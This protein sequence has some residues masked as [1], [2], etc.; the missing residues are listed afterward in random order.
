[1]QQDELARSIKDRFLAA[2]QTAST[3]LEEMKRLKLAHDALSGNEV[4]EI[5]EDKP[6]ESP[7]PAEAPPKRTRKMKPTLS[8]DDVREVLREILRS[9]PLSEKIVREKVGAFAKEQG[10]AQ[11]SSGHLPRA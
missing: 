11:L 7:S 6:S 10:A 1:M 2:L 3:I 9:A 4:S 5:G 8:R